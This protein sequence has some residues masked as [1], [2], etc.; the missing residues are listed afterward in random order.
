MKL[1]KL[2]ITT[3]LFLLFTQIGL[4]QTHSCTHCNM[5]IKN[6]AFKAKIETKTGKTLHFDAIECLVNYLNS[7]NEK[8]FNKLYVTDYDQQRYINAENAFYLKSDAIKSPMGANLSAYGSLEEPTKKQEEKEG[9]IFTWLQL[10]ERFVSSGLG[11]TNHLHH[12]NANSYAPVGIMGDHLHPQGGLMVSLR[13]MNMNMDG[14]REGSDKISNDAIYENY[15]VA[16]QKMTM[17]MYMLGIMYAPSD[18]LTLM[19][20]QNFISK[21]MDLTAQMTMDNGMPM[22]TD[23]STSSSG[24]GDLKAGF[25]YGLISH[26][27]FSL[28]SNFT[29]NIPIGDIENRDDTPMMVDAKLPYAMQLG[30]GTFDLTIGATLKGNFGDFS[31][32][33]QPLATIRT[34]ENSQDYRFGNLFELNS[35]LGYGFSKTISSSLRLSGST[36]G[37]IHNVDSD[38]NPMMVT[39]ADTNNYGGELVRGAL[40]LNVL[41]LKSKLVFSA[42]IVSPLYQN[43]NGVF[44]N[45]KLTLNG[46]LKYTIL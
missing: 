45:E 33:I 14:N 29:L 39:T 34:G 25:L 18:N 31:W 43:Y 38:L 6:K 2:H 32:G 37:E 26:E 40:G 35:W 4:S 3:I 20:M 22:L 44:M 19:L 28:H 46:A 5:V 41:L 30:S 16:P 24:I 15:M 10:R 1:I 36:E 11:A 27:K 12:H 7:K 17:Q 42:E 8:T 9:E 13:Y 23:F 21:N